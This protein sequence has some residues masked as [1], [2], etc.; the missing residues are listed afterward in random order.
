MCASIYYFGTVIVIVSVSESE[1]ESVIVIVVITPVAY[2][3]RQKRFHSCFLLS[4]DAL[5]WQR[6]SVTTIVGKMPV[7]VIWHKGL[8][9]LDAM[10]SPGKDKWT[11]LSLYKII[12]LCER[13][14]WS[15]QVINSQQ[16]TNSLCLHLAQLLHR[17]SIQHQKLSF[18][19]NPVPIPPLPLISVPFQF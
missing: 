2:L 13:P 19:T 18:S 3:S 1:S 11:Q 17:S 4:P 9:S 6:A 5:P 8:A 16:N 10:R 7:A 12:K 14:S 15:S